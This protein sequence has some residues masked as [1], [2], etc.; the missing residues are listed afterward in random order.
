MHERIE[1][2][3]SYVRVGPEV[4]LRVEQSGS[5]EQ[6]VLFKKQWHPRVVGGANISACVKRSQTPYILL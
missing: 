2:A 5:R 4:V 3:S 1:I 6:F